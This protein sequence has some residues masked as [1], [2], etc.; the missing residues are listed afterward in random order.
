MKYSLC[1]CSD[2]MFVKQL[3]DSCVVCLH[4]DNVLTIWT[5]HFSISLDS[6]LSCKINREIPNEHLV[7]TEHSEVQ[8]LVLFTCGF[9]SFVTVV[10]FFID[11]E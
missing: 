6:D 2:C 3:F 1:L 4:G 5:S 8:V 11:Y 7:D 10:V 9:L